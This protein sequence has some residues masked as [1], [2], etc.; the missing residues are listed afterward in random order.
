MAHP[1]WETWADL[2]HPDCQEILDQLE[3]N[4]E[5]YQ[6]QIPPRTDDE[7]TE[8]SKK[9]PA[10]TTDCDVSDTKGSNNA[11]EAEA[12]P[13]AC[14]FTLTL[15]EESSDL[16]GQIKQMTSPPVAVVTSQHPVR[17]HTAQHSNLPGSKHTHVVHK[18][19]T[20]K[21]QEEEREVSD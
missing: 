4:R 15:E 12:N 16:T 19:D 13:G 17:T 18:H 7:D 9:T 10:D 11:N 2:V 3:E 21:I 20:P 1:L 6:S 14:Q 5:Y 8:H